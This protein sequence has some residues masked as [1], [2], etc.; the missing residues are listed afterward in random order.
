MTGTKNN[1]GRGSG[2]RELTVRVKTSRGRTASSQRWLERQLNDPYVARSKREGYRSRAAYKLIEIDDKHHILAPGMR[3]VDLGA[4]PGG[5]SQV[6]IERVGS[7]DEDKRV[8]AIDY[9]EMDELPGVILFQKD[10]LDEDAPALL[11]QAL[12]GLADVVMSD[13]AAPTTGHQKT[14]HLRTIYLCEVAVDFALNV[15]KPGGHFLTKVF[16]GGAENTVLTQLK[17]N[18]AS[19]YHIKP[20]ASRA[21]SVEL[22]LLAKGFKG[23]KAAPET[24]AAA[25]GGEDESGWRP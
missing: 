2:G 11:E 6:A 17:Q 18:F 25:E 14:D 15:L 21:G 24:A 4:A 23:R 19:V 7:T 12:G 8:V 20:P 10:F 22:F 1:S 16:R 13:M 5:W 9:L 3:V